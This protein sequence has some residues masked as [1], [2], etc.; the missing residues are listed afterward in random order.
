M[1]FN[2]IHAWDSYSVGGEKPEFD[3]LAMRW[4]VDF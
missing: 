1:M 3:I 2:Y 4:Q